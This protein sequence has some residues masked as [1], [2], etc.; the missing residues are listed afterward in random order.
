MR[1]CHKCGTPLDEKLEVFRASTCPSCSA[2]LKCCLNCQFYSPGA[3][4]DCHE[5][6]DEQVVDKARANFCSWFRFRVAGGSA[7]GDA[8][9]GPGRTGKA[10]DTF[11]KLFGG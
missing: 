5:T 7:P 3:H 8:A 10:Q 4:W 6:I 11:D 2:D 9:R 1:R